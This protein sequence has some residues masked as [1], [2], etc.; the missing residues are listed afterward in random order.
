MLNRLIICFVFVITNSLF[1]ISQS[2]AQNVNI[3]NDSIHWELLRKS[4]NFISKDSI[5][6]SKFFIKVMDYDKQL[7]NI[8]NLDSNSIMMLL[9]DKETDWATNL[10][11]YAIHFRSADL[12]FVF[13][14][15][16]RLEWIEYTKEDDIKY[17]S[18]I[19]SK[20]I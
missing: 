3:S 4:M 19:Y 11:L 14:I 8:K 5:D 15:K 16:T 2:R 7:D 13:R 9:Q 17:W 6:E 1:T 18:K 10:L 20:E 12:F